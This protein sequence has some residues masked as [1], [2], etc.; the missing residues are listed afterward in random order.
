MVSVA[1]FSTQEPAAHKPAAH[2]PEEKKK[3]L[4]SVKLDPKINEL[5]KERLGLPITKVQFPGGRSR[6]SY[7]AILENGQTIIVTKR[8]TKERSQLECRA[9]S[10]LSKAGM[11]V[12]D[13]LASDGHLFF[14]QD[15][16]RQRLSERLHACTTAS[17]RLTLLDNAMVGLSNIQHCASDA[18]LDR[19]VPT[20]GG[21]NAWRL[22]F[23]ELPQT[24]GQFMGLTAPAVNTDAVIETLVVR[25]PRFVKW[26]ARPGNALVNASNEVIWVDWEHC[27]ARNRLDDLAWLLAD[28]YNIDDAASESE[29]LNRHLDKFKDERDSNTAFEYLMVYGTLHTCVRLGMI[30]HR[31]DR[32]KGGREGHGKNKRDWWDAEYCMAGD[33]IGV[34]QE[35]AVRQCQRAS[36]WAANSSLLNDLSK[37]F[38][39]VEHAIVR[40]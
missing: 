4:K 29:L 37:W 14:Q 26:D 19:V 38:N 32:N 33:K 10:T 15:V 8:K 17:E 2:K 35:M 13:L 22:Q 5:A 7:R 27:G 28:E 34:T 11:P 3:S 6:Q 39:Q 31:K 25:H 24:I 21:D 23:A 1:K 40:L 36:R 12:P 16:G 30:L 9:L 18:G 20:L